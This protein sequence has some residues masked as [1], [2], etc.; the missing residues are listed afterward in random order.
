MMLHAQ[1]TASQGTHG[2]SID[3]HTR[4]WLLECL[5][6]QYSA[7]ML[8]G[9]RA[10]G[11]ARA[12]SDFDLLQIVAQGPRSYSVGEVNITAYTSEH[13]RK[14]ARRGSLFVRHLK[15]EGVPLTDEKAHLETILGLYD[16]PSSYEPLKRELR[17]VL[18]V[19]ARRG[20]DGYADGARKLAAFVARTALYV[21]TAELG[22]P[23]FDVERAADCAG[24]PA[25]GPML[26]QNAK[27]PLRGLLSH[28]SS[29]LNVDLHPSLIAAMPLDFESAALWAG[30][31][32]PLAGSLL[33]RVIADETTIDYTA[34]TLPCT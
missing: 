1:K 27:P 26:R 14:L 18:L 13:L 8:Y 2:P 7:A 11:D 3:R 24:R 34:L 33:E 30:S 31:N 20:A 5:Q 15:D 29:L 12:E 6:G 19:L 25:L 21:R 17:V 28:G 4:E 22:K 10:R 32:Y 16:E 9:S 23:V